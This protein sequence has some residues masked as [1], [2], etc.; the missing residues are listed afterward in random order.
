[1][2][3]ARGCSRAVA[4]V[5]VTT[6]VPVLSGSG[7]WQ[8]PQLSKWTR[9]SGTRSVPSPHLGFPFPLR[10]ALCSG[11]WFMFRGRGGARGR[12]GGAA[13][14]LNFRVPHSSLLA[15]PQELACRGCLPSK[16]ALAPLLFPGVFW[17]CRDSSP[18]HLWK[19]FWMC[20]NSSRGT[21]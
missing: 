12:H 18:E 9:R 1:M 17:M 3:L 10:R 11:E 13:A 6:R 21:S 2:E 15:P 8:Q 14:P 7:K 20:Y 4:R 19:Q 5:A 16:E